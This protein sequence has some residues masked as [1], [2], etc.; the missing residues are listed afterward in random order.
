MNDGQ[1]ERRIQREG[2]RFVGS[3]D[4]VNSGKKP[5]GYISDMYTDIYW[6][7]PSTVI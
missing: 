2:A 5:V 4:E 1:M 3:R 6:T 7:T